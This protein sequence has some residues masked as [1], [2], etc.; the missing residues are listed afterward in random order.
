VVKY[1]IVYWSHYGNGKKLVCYLAS[2]LKEAGSEV[3]VL[4]TDEA[5]PAHLPAADVYVFSAPTQALRL[6]GGMRRFLRR[7][8][9]MQGLSYGIINT[10][11]MK[12]GSRL[13]K[14]EALLRKKGMVKRAEL[15]FLVGEGTESGNG[16]PPGWETALDRFAAR[17]KP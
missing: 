4:L 1:V 2:A 10:H 12:N 16:L 11:G 3:L 8:R 15:D 17:L 7:L 13:G 14:M 5:D 9:D 6:V